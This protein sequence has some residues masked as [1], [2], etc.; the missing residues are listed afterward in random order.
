MNPR[1]LR[2]GAV[3]LCAL[4]FLSIGCGDGKVK[5][6]PVTGQVLYN[7]EPLPGVSLAFHPLDPKNNTGFPPTAKTDQEGK[8]SLMT[9]L[10]NDGAPAGDFKVAIAFEVESVVD[11]SDQSKRLSFQIPAKYHKAETSDLQV[12][13]KPGKNNLDPFKLEG[14]PKRKR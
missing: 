5:V 1:V 10:P 2:V 3:M 13:V 14:P 12:T 7:G 9:F 6:Y 8:F 11:G 4:A